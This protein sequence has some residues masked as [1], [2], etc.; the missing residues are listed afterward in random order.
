MCV[1]GFVS[2]KGAQVPRG[3]MPRGRF[4]QGVW[5]VV[6]SLTVFAVAALGAVS[7]IIGCLTVM[8]W[9][10]N[11]LVNHQRSRAR[12]EPLDSSPSMRDRLVEA[13]QTPHAD[14]AG[15]GGA[16][17]VRRLALRSCPGGP[18]AHRRAEHVGPG[19]AVCTR[20]DHL[21]PSRDQGHRVRKS[22]KSKPGDTV[23]LTS[24]SSAEDAAA[25]CQVP[26]GTTA[27]G[28]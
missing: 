10:E 16:G 15:S 1:L 7:M 27:C 3:L 25:R 5:L 11:R 17:D 20:G 24:V 8:L 4:A 6:N 14:D 13:H 18:Q 21:V 2:S 22:A 12:P 19:E 26:A 23:Q 28:T 9:V